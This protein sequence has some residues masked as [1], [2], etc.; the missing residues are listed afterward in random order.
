M[1]LIG[2]SDCLWYLCLQYTCY[3]LNR[4]AHDKLKGKTPIEASTGQTPDISALLNFNFFESIF[5][6][7]KTEAFPLSKEKLGWWIGVAEKSGDVMTYKIL[8]IDNEVIVRSII[9]KADNPIHPN[10]RVRSRDD[11]KFKL[12]SETDT[13]DVT[14]LN[15]SDVDPQ[16]V[17][18]R[19][20]I[21]D[22]N[23]HP[24]KIKV[25][26]QLG[27]GKHLAEVGDDTKEE[28]ITYN[29]ILDHASRKLLQESLIMPSCLM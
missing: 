20:Y 26:E 12:E 1:D 28:T 15:L 17:I 2:I 16:E 27:E 11:E 25:K 13:I 29:E 3:L 23:G 18:G 10:R 24:H 5:Y 7:D 4:L 19:A 8:T 9:R 21:K 14:Q 6:Y 22:I